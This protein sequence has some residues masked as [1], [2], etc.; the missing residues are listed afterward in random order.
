APITCD[1]AC[2]TRYIDAYYAALLANDPEALPQAANA[3]ITLNG[4]EVTLADAFWDEAMTVR[5]RFD[6]VNERLGATGSQ[7]VVVNEDGSDTMETVLLKIE[8]GAIT[9]MEFVRVVRGD[10]GEVWWGPEQLDPEPSAFLKLPIPPS[11]RD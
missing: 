4:K 8:E 5:W 9:G 11:E 2:L 6:I 3:R 1:R 7:V 10:A